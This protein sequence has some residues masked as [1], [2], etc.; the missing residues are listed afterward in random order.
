MEL[1]DSEGAR[2]TSQG[3]EIIIIEDS[4]SIKPVYPKVKGIYFDKGKNGWFAHISLNRNRIEKYC[5]AGL[6]GYRKAIF[7]RQELEKES[8][9]I[10][11]KEQINKL[12][13]FLKQENRQ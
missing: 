2:T 3:P 4:G 10:K 8:D 9:K 13:T 1:E 11:L 6:E 12:K 7:I 5:G